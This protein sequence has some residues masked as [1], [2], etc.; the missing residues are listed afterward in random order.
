[1]MAVKSEQQ[2]AAGLGIDRVV[3]LR[4]YITSEKGP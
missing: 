1:M 3:L 4:L 2:Q